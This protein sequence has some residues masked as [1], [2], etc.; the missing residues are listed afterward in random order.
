MRQRSST[1]KVIVHDAYKSFI[2]EHHNKLILQIALIPIVPFILVLIETIYWPGPI[3]CSDTCP[4]SEPW[5]SD[6]GLLTSGKL[7][8]IK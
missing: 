5:M 4:R 2:K 6:V 3:F 8:S 7:F 1:T